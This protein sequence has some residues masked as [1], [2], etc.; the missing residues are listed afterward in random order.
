MKERLYLRGKIYWCWHYGSDPQLIRETTT[1]TDRSAACA[2]LRRGEQE[3]QGAAPQ[4]KSYVSLGD[5]FTSLEK[6]VEGNT[7]PENTHFVK[8]QCKQL[9]SGLGETTDGTCQRT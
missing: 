5:A 1:F 7:T 6:W 4:R 2:V 8:A 3:A 9:R